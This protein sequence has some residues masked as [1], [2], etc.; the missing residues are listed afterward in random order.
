MQCHSI[1]GRRQQGTSTMSRGAGGLDAARG[2][3]AARTAV[4]AA[5]R[6]F[7]RSVAHCSIAHPVDLRRFAGPTLV[8]WPL[9]EHERT[10]KTV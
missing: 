9:S 5:R 3:V 4:P 2:R 7:Q 10:V 1:S 6:N 8:A